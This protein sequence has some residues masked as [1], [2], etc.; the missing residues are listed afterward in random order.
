MTGMQ[1]TVLLYP[2]VTHV[3]KD[4]AP[5][6]FTDQVVMYPPAWMGL[7]RETTSV[8]RCMGPVIEALW[9]AGVVTHACCCGHGRYAPSVYV[10]IGI[11]WWIDQD[12]KRVS[13]LENKT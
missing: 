13:R 4:N 8:D 6:L 1:N 10:E 2:R 9:D 5:G 12:N 7:S 11:P 3:C